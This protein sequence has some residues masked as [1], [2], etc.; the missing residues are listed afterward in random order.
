MKSIRVNKANLIETIEKNRSEH[1]ALFEKAQE[2][3][4]ERV[5]ELLDER[6]QQARAGK[7][8]DIAIRL[9]E[10][11]DYTASYDTALSMLAWE[12]GD[13]V[14]L[15]RDDFE[16]YVENNW[17]WRNHWAGTTQVYLAE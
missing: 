17:E 5:I 6:L 11:V 4:R 14:D 1:R 9:P 12:E 8:F 13:T 10:P 3:Y 15:D 2:K 16:R 7:Q